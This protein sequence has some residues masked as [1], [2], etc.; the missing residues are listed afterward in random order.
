M[1]SCGSAITVE[2]SQL[3]SSPSASRGLLAGV[4]LIGVEVE[5]PQGAS[6]VVVLTLTEQNI[7]CVP[8][9]YYCFVTPFTKE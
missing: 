9:E 8:K 2:S 6:S 1:E 3:S 4:G 5:G 7:V